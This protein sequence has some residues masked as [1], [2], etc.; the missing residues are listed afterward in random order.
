MKL[1]ELFKAV[2]EKT[3]TK[4]Q[5][6]AYRDELAS[7][8]ADMQFEMADI[9]KLKAVYF[10]EK[11]QDLATSDKAMERNWQATPEGLREIELTHYIK[12]TEKILSSLKSR[13]Y[14]MYV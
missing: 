3:L 12:G 8:Y 9:R 11:R 5:L 4:E 10:V 1:L 13:L 7:V 6:E 2:K 14:G